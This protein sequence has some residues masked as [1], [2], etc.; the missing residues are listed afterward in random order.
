M[1]KTFKKITDILITIS[2]VI[3]SA[4]GGAMMVFTSYD[5]SPGGL[6]LGLVIIL[7]SIYMAIKEKTATHKV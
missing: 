5:D 7:F 2:P 4:I 3:L 1:K 6:L